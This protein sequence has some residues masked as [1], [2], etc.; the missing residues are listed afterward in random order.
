MSSLSK[1]GHLSCKCKITLKCFS[2][3]GAHHLAICDSYEQT[4]GEQEQVE[5]VANVSTSIYLDQSRGV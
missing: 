2:C 1:S 3:Q 4:L 5:N